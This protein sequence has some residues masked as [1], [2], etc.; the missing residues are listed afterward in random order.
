MCT[1]LVTYD[2]QN[3]IAQN[4]M[5]VLAMTTGVEI[6]DDVMFTDKEPSILNNIR[7]GL[8]EVRLFNSGKMETTSAKDFLYEL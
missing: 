6:D 8:E 5:E 7:A 4:L 3:R 2:P 1:V